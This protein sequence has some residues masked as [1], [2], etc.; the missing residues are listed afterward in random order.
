MN[1]SV[2]CEFAVGTI[3]HS[4]PES[5]AGT[6][7]QAPDMAARKNSSSNAAVDRSIFIV[8]APLLQPLLLIDAAPPAGQRLTV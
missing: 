8:T 3:L 4:D 2:I 7:V 5:F 1:L 6:F